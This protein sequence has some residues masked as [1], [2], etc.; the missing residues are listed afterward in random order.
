MIRDT[1][2]ESESGQSLSELFSSKINALAVQQDFIIFADDENSEVWEYNSAMGAF[3][4][5]GDFAEYKL[6]QI[7]C[8][9][10]KGV[11][12]LG[13]KKDERYTTFH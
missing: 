1:A 7:R 12:A 6:S 13:E 5:V 2:S 4:R 8:L 10:T 11:V 9:G 3:E